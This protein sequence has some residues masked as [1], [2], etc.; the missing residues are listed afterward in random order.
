MSDGKGKARASGKGDE[1]E[2]SLKVDAKQPP[3]ISAIGRVFDSAKGL[4]G[5]AFFGAPNSNELNERTSS[6]SAIGGK[7][8]QSTSS[9]SS[10]WA[11]SSRAANAYDD[12]SS[13]IG[14]GATFRSSTEQHAASVEAEFSDFLN[15]IPSFQS[16]DEFLHPDPYLNA[17]H[18]NQPA[19]NTAG[20]VYEYPQASYTVE[21]QEARDGQEVLNLLSDP[22]SQIDEETDVYNGQKEEEPILWQMTDLQRAQ[23][24]ERLRTDFP[25]TGGRTAP[26][27]DHS[28]YLIPSYET[29]SE[30]EIQ[31]WLD[32]WRDVFTRYTDEVWGNLLPIV[33]EARVEVEKIQEQPLSS[34]RPR[35]L[36]R[37]GMILG[38]LRQ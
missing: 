33:K 14:P 19:K 25:D 27:V 6:A 36:R 4:A 13:R 32:Q 7:A 15:G 20:A 24:H 17:Y 37:L 30:D 5:N 8:P 21:E 12:S 16:F 26:T 9:R 29:I 2:T 3:P 38:H 11:E 10:A 18:D 34:E 23:W 1:N 35:A 31:Q 22:R 28:M